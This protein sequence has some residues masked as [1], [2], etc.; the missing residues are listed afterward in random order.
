MSESAGSHATIADGL[1]KERVALYC[2]VSTK[3][4]T[5]ENKILPLK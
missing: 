3:E 5:V 1:K 2:R 4:Q